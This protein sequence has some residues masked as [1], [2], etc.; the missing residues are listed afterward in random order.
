MNDGRSFVEVTGQYIII[1]EDFSSDDGDGRIVKIN[2]N[3]RCSDNVQ[4]IC[5]GTHKMQGHSRRTAM[6]LF[7]G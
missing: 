7:Y 5:N 3:E 1:I 4:D 6:A 2:D